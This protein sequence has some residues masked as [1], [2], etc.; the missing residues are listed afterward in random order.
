M[1]KD[2]KPLAPQRSLSSRIT[3]DGE[4]VGSLAS[5]IT[6]DDEPSQGRLRDDNYGRLK[7]DFSEPTENSFQEP[8]TASRDLASR[9]TWARDGGGNRRRSNEDAGYSIRGSA[10]QAEGFSIRGAAGGE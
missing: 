8:T 10:P 1:T 2:G 5:R 9:I 6:R 7:D 3:R 4:P